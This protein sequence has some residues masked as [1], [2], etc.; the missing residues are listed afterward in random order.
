M[1]GDIS[2]ISS[3]NRVPPFAI[4]TSPFFVS[5]A[6]VKAPFSWPKSSF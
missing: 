3:R 1:A 2:V 4:S 6:P 5:S